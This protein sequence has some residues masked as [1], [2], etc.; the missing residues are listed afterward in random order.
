M[1]ATD[2]KMNICS[3]IKALSQSKSD[4]GL[5]NLVE[6]HKLWGIEKIGKVHYEV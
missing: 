1:M 4:F 6:I 5:Q 3:Q 2:A